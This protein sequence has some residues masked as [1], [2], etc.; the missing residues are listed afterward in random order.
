[1]ALKMVENQNIK[2]SFLEPTLKKLEKKNQTTNQKIKCSNNI[3]N[4]FDT[5]LFMLQINYF[6]NL[7]TLKVDEIQN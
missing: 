7:F 2:F 6:F 5:N 3:F 4:F 1:M